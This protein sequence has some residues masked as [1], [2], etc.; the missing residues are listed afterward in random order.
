MRMLTGYQETPKKTSS[1]QTTVLDFFKSSVETHASPFVLS[2]KGG[3]DPNNQ[4]IV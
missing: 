3:D 4:A 2:D 1:R